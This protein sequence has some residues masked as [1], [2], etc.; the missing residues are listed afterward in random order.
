MPVW[1]RSLGYMTLVFAAWLVAAP[2]AL[3][4][5]ERGRFDLA[6]RAPP[7]PAIGA[8]TLMLG[9]ALAL[10]AGG[11]LTVVGR[12]T[13]WP[14]DPPARLVTTGPYRLVRNPLAIAL[15]LMVAGEAL[16]IRSRLLWVIWPL[17]LAYLQFLAGP[18][19][20]R[21][22]KALH[23]RDYLA[24][25]ARVGKWLPRSTRGETPGPRAH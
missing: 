24:Y 3:L 8:A 25:K 11:Y 10:V 18:W 4:L 19:E 16:V 2:A 1:F 7:W 9:Q 15:L 21:Q 14:L 5:V 20:D 6:L 13:P 12:G 17:T 23:G 22:L